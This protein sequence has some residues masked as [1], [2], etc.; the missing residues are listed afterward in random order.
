MSRKIICDCCGEE[1][2]NNREHV[3][4]NISIS[5]PNNNI[6]MQEFEDISL[7]ISGYRLT[8]NN[9]DFCKPCF[10]RIVRSILPLAEKIIGTWN[11]PKV[12]LDEGE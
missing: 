8:S 10:E 1:I 12:Y 11:D 4:D 7:L 9:R 6:S 5:I 2:I 3:H